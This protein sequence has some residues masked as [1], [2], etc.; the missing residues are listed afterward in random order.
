V[1]NG[2]QGLVHA[3]V[4]MCVRVR[5]VRGTHACVRPMR[6]WGC[7]PT[8]RALL[9]TRALR[10]LPC[11]VYVCV[12]EREQPRGGIAHRSLPLP[13][14]QAQPADR[15]PQPCFNAFYECNE[16]RSGAWGVGQAAAPG[17]PF[18]AFRALSFI[19]LSSPC[20]PCTHSL[21]SCGRGASK[22]RTP[23]PVRSLSTLCG[24][25]PGA[26]PPSS[27]TP[28]P[29]SSEQQ[30]VEARLHDS[31]RVRHVRAQACAPNHLCRHCPQLR[32]EECSL[33]T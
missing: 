20:T 10:W 17:L 29:R 3:C 7:F 33:K 2:V 32:A 28:S 5:R 1:E 14:C 16:N 31:P 12:R 18:R 23:R 21:G 19:C 25:P 22:E 6:A 15:G 24:M 4:C 8:R 30:L 13:S 26:P 11:G 27:H 9:C